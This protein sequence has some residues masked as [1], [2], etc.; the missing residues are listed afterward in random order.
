MFDAVEAA[1]NTPAH[2]KHHRSVALDEQ[3]EGGLFLSRQEALQQ[4]S[5]RQIGVIGWWAHLAQITEHIAKHRFR[6]MAEPP[7]GAL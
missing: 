5:V 7:Q 4:L 1:K 3:G 2:A 6:H